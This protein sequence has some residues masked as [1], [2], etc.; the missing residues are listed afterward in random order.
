[1]PPTRE[2]LT[3]DTLEF[4]RPDRWIDASTRRLPDPAR[5]AQT[6]DDPI[7]PRLMGVIRRHP[8]VT[9]E[10]LADDADV[11]R[12][13]VRSRLQR[14]EETGLVVSQIQGAHRLHFPASMDRSLRQAITLLH[15]GSIRRLVRHLLGDPEIGLCVCLADRL[16][17]SV[18]AVRRDL[19]RLE[20]EGLLEIR[21]E[22]DTEIATLH[23]CLGAAV[24]WRNETE[25]NQER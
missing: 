4:T 1:M 12:E 3:I 16:E 22:D 7:L 10:A 21:S 9:L 24:H 19:E 18:G 20:A 5:G 6:S 17:I 14:L 11:D 15:V 8:G 2:P 13:I 25:D 23:P